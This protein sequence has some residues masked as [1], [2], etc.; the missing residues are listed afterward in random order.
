V[1]TVL[2]FVMGAALAFV[3][4]RLGAPTASGSVALLTFVLVFVLVGRRAGLREP[5]SW[6]RAGLLTIV[7]SCL[8]LWV[9]IA[10][11]AMWLYG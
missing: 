10:G 7:L 5:G 4:A 9:G 1:S 11:Y 8:V 6:V 2:G 3:S